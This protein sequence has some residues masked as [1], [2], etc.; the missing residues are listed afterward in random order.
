[1]YVHSST[2]HNNTQT[3]EKIQMSTNRCIDNKLLY[4]G[5]LFKSLKK[6]VLD[7]FSSVDKTQKYY[8][9]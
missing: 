6:W 8:A 1:M 2:I 7:V 3:V 5:I 9:T 4:T